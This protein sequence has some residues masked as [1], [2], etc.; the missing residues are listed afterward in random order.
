METTILTQASEKIL[1]LGVVGA[2][3]LILGGVIAVLYRQN[4]ALHAAR[5][6][7]IKEA[8]KT[9]ETNSVETKQT[10]EIMRQVL[11]A[12]QRTSGNEQ[13][14]VSEVRTKLTEFMDDLRKGK[15]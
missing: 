3:F 15:P 8:A 5:I 12:M 14:V 9:M 2:V 13:I 4:Q 6:T 1:S 11:S 7:D 10:A